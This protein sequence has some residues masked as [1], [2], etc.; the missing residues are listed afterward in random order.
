[1]YIGLSKSCGC[2]RKENGEKSL[3]GRERKYYGGRV[4]EIRFTPFLY[5]EENK[6]SYAI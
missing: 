4:C 1:M 3:N 2:Y 6:L 5:V